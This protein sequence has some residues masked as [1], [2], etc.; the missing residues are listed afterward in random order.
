MNAVPHLAAGTM[1]MPFPSPFAK[2]PGKGNS[3]PIVNAIWGFANLIVGLY[4]FSTHPFAF[5][6]NPRF[7][8]AALAAFAIAVQLSWHFGR[9][10]AAK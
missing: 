8:V 4:L 9:V 7:G 10:R 6:A 2:P 1:G 3:P 5:D